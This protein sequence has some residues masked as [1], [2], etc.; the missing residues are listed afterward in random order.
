MEPVDSIIALRGSISFWHRQA[1]DQ[2]ERGT[3]S[4]EEAADFKER[5]EAAC[6]ALKTEACPFRGGQM[7]DTSPLKQFGDSCDG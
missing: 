5:F 7:L 6:A 1:E 4:R 3:R 2:I